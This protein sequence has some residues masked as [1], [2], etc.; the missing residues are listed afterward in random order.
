MALAR[1][2][3]LGRGR[4]AQVPKERH[5]PRLKPPVP[6]KPDRTRPPVKPKSKRD[7]ERDAQDLMRNLTFPS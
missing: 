1:V 2:G 6:P 7:V 5:D 3:D 4:S